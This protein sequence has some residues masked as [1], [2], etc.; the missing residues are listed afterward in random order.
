MW[1]ATKWL[2]IRTSNMA[3]MPKGTSL[4]T[5]EINSHGHVNK[6]QMPDRG[7]WW[8]Q[9]LRWR[10]HE[11]ATA[12]LVW[13]SVQ[14]WLCSTH[15][16]KADTHMEVNNLVAMVTKILQYLHYNSTVDTYVTDSCTKL[17]FL[18]VDQFYCF[19]QKRERLLTH[20]PVDNLRH[21]CQIGDWS[22][23]WHN[24]LRPGRFF[25]RGLK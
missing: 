11:L 3:C 22:V 2:K 16:I 23:T 7:L 24:V 6:C 12:W 13:P 18:L 9:H 17:G 8:F 19:L 20:L 1:I 25:R 5:P 14:S 4:M 10:F 21:E 15:T